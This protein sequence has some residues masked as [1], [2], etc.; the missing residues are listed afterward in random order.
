[1]I[2]YNE[3][4]LEV[5]AVKRN[6]LICAW[7]CVAFIMI[8]GCHRGKI[9]EVQIVLGESELYS[10]Q[11]L[12]AAADIILRQFSNGFD[13]CTLRELSYNEE[14]SLKEADAWAKQYEA[15]EAIV[16]SS[17]FVVSPDYGNGPFS[18]GDTHYYSWILVKDKN[19]D[20]V[21]KT[22]GY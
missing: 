10:E 15:K 1:M 11:E 21:L 22:W 4:S 7:L 19:N 6:L 9:D 20:W 16:F 2:C 18:P 3:N 14:D 17:R 13:G 12:Q 5:K 8:A